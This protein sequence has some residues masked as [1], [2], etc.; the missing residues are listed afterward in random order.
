MTIISLLISITIITFILHHL[1]RKF[2][3]LSKIVIPFEIIFVMLITL[4]IVGTKHGYKTYDITI[5]ELKQGIENTPVYDTNIPDNITNS[6]LIFYKFDCN[7]CQSIYK[8]LEYELSF[9]NNIPIYHVNTQ[10][11]IGQE[12]VKKYKITSVPTGVYIK[13]D[14]TY[15]PYELAKTVSN[16]KIVLSEIGFSQLVN[17]IENQ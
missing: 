11:D 4:I 16:D 10:S 8:D 13:D 15:Y 17:H 12:L 5:T 9:Y 6:I 1:S 3:I 14:D 2:K 7:A